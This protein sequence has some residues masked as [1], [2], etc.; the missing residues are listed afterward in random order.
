MQNQLNDLRS[1]LRRP[2]VLIL[3]VALAAQAA[4]YYLL[5]RSSTDFQVRPLSGFDVVIGPWAETGNYPV[6]D[7]VRSVLRA[8]DTLNR[9]Y[10]SPDQPVSC[11]LFVAF[12]KSQATGAA[13]H[14]PK[15]CLPGSGWTPV[16]S[17]IVEIDLPALGRSIE[18]NRYIVARGSERTL[19]YY[20]Y[21]TPY[22]TVASEY[23]AKIWLVLD[24][25]RYH[26]SDTSLVRVVAAL[27]PDSVQQADAAATD[28]IRNV[29]PRLEAY[30]PH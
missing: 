16:E 25:L 8:D 3:S 27:P 14:S 13:P 9:V 19:V 28:F 10:S 4:G 18:A 11:N 29:F 24:S 7:E 5:P 17:S 20:W 15:N 30:L 26:R 22:R 1:L 12:F 23:K 2:V 21:Q 6:E